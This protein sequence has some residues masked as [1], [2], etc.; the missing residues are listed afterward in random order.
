MA[1]PIID[2]REGYTSAA[3]L[4]DNV[5]AHGKPEELALIVARGPRGAAALAGLAVFILLALW[6]G[7]FFFVFLPRGAIG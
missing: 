7:F 2:P 4:V 1:N 3:A 6:F 5:A